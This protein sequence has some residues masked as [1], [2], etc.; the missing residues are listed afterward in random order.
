MLRRT[1]L[2]PPASPISLPRRRL[3]QGSA[4]FAP[5]P[6]TA[7]GGAGGAIPCTALAMEPRQRIS[8]QAS[9]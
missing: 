7:V 4:C 6:P 9:D 8:K 1:L 3:C 5:P 2:A